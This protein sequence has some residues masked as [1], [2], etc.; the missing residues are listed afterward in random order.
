MVYFLTPLLLNKPYNTA[1]AIHKLVGIIASCLAYV[2]IYS[3]S[4]PFTTRPQVYDSS[5]RDNTTKVDCTCD[6]QECTSKKE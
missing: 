2:E 3:V 4:F 1:E 6:K 5:I